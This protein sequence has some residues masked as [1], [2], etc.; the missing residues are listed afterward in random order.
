MKAQVCDRCGLV[1]SADDADANRWT[2]VDVTY[3]SVRPL[4]VKSY[5]FCRDCGDGGVEALI[6]QRRRDVA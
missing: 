4:S 2:R 6:E 1:Q 3:G 5:H